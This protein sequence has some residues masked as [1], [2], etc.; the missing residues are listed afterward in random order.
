MQCVHLALCLTQSQLS[1]NVNY[2]REKEN[3]KFLSFMET[4]R[5]EG[6]RMVPGAHAVIEDAVLKETVIVPV[7][8]LSIYMSCHLY[9]HYLV[10]TSSIHPYRWTLSSHI[11]PL[12]NPQLSYCI[13]INPRS[14][15]F[16]FSINKST[17]RQATES[18]FLFRSSTSLG[19][20]Q[21]PVALTK[22]LLN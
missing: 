18:I 10:Y 9:V 14:T 3:S 17:G 11:Q 6:P 22:R 2:P 13:H 7:F 16:I 19:S 12:L 15:R 20:S 8:S 1:V 21:V 5:C 4:R